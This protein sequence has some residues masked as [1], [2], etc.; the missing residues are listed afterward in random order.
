MIPGIHLSTLLSGA[1]NA[2][3]ARWLEHKTNRQAIGFLRNLWRAA[4]Y[5][6][7]ALPPAAGVLESRGVVL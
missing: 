7:F 1:R 2:R 5:D 3:S 4:A 6:V